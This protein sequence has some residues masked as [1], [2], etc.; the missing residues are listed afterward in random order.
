MSDAD[1][2]AIAKAAGESVRVVFHGEDFINLVANIIDGS[3]DV[4]LKPIRERLDTIQGG[5]RAAGGEAS[6]APSLPCP[7]PSR[8]RLAAR[9]LPDC[10]ATIEIRK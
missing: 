7:V 9:L 6:F 4:K 1:L 2:A 10:S 3:L 8:L 5:L